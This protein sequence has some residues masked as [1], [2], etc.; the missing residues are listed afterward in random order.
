MFKIME[1]IIHDLFKILYGRETGSRAYTAAFDTLEKYK[2]KL[3][4][5]RGFTPGEFPLTEKDSF[6]ITYGDS[7]LKEGEMPL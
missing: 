5:P 6:C 1:Q 3:K 2:G 7:I 4:A